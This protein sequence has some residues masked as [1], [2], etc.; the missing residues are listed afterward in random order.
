VKI[1]VVEYNKSNNR[2]HAFNVE[3]P[4]IN[5]RNDGKKIVQGPVCPSEWKGRLDA[6]SIDNKPTAEESAKNSDHNK[7]LETSSD[8]SS[9]LGPPQNFIETITSLR[10]KKLTVPHLVS[11]R[12]KQYN[13]MNRDSLFYEK[14]KKQIL[15]HNTSQKNVIC[16][17]ELELKQM[18]DDGLKYVPYLKAVSE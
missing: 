4:E 11:R 13:D 18:M 8:S 2:A 3:K 1:Y 15:G 12:S 5:C 14:N 9:D 16:N 10:M 7:S 6:Y 17:S